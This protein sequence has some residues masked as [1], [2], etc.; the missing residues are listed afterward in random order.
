MAIDPR[1]TALESLL[2][3]IYA[4]SAECLSID[5]YD[6]WGAQHDTEEKRAEMYA[7]GAKASADHDSSC[8]E[9]RNAVR[10]LR[11][12]AP[13]LVRAWAEAHVVLL[14]EYIASQ[15]EGSTERFVANEEIGGW[16]EVADGTKDFVDENTFYVRV[17][18]AR[19]KELLG[20]G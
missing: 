11:A 2:V 10:S 19:R 9:L 5:M 18:R 1:V 7:I 6:R 13:E 3:R 12:E 4:A 20:V 14:T 8:G 16:R 17:D 15:P